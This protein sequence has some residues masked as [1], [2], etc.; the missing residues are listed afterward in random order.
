MWKMRSEYIILTGKPEWRR[1]LGK[2]CCRCE[3]N[4]EMGFRDIE[5]GVDWIHVAQNT[6]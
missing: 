3:D 6:D 4:R 5:T 1:P 2:L